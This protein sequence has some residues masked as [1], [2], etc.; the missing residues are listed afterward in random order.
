MWANNETGTLFP[1]AEIAEI[2]KRK[3]VYF[4]HRRSAGP[5]VKYR[6]VFR[7]QEFNSRPFQDT[8]YTVL[9]ELG[10]VVLIAKH[11][12]HPL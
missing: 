10:A 12:S 4:S 5:L 6:L 3:G 1:I 7:T 8:S 11:D 2:T 9:R